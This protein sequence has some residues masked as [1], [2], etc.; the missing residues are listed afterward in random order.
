MNTITNL[1]TFIIRIRSRVFAQLFVF[2]TIGIFSVFE[3]IYAVNSNTRNTEHEQFFIDSHVKDEALIK[4]ALINNGNES[5]FHLFT[6]GKPGEL[7]I[8]NKWLDA[9]GIANFIKNEIHSKPITHINIY[10]CEFAKGQKGKEA[11]SYLETALGVSVSASNNITGKDGDWNL[12]VG[13]V[14]KIRLLED[15]NYNLQSCAGVVGGTN[16]GDDYDG[17]GICNSDDLDDDNDGILDSNEC[18]EALELDFEQIVNTTATPSSPTSSTVTSV[19]TTHTVTSSVE[20]IADAGSISATTTSFDRN[21]TGDLSGILFSGDMNQGDSKKAI[22]TFDRPVYNL[23]FVVTDTDGNDAITFNGSLD[24]VPITLTSDNFSPIAGGPFPSQTGNTFSSDFSAGP[25]NVFQV[26]FNQP[27]DRLEILS[28]NTTSPATQNVQKV[29]DLQFESGCDTDGDNIPDY[30]DLDSDNDGCP[31]A[32]ESASSPYIYADLNADGS[33]NL[34]SFPV[35]TNSSSAT[36]G[37]PNSQAYLAGSSKD[38]NQVSPECDSCNSASSLYADIDGDGVGNDCDLDNDNDGILD[39]SEGCYDTNFAGNDSN[40]VGI[41]NTVYISYPFGTVKDGANK[42][43]SRSNIANIIIPSSIST[44]ESGPGFSTNVMGSYSL[45]V[46][47]IDAVTLNQAIA[48]NEYLEFSFKTVP[49]VFD[50]NIDWFGF[51][52]RVNTNP[53]YTVTYQI[54]NDGFSSNVTTLG[55]V[56]QAD[57]EGGG[58]YPVGRRA[59]DNEN[60]NLY[61]DKDYTVRI[62]IYNVGGPS[63]VLNFDDPILA[64]DYCISDVDGDGILNYLDSDSD[65]DGCP[66]ALEGNGGFTYSDLD[67]DVLTTGTDVDGNGVPIEAS[68][69]QGA[70]TAYNS[71]EQSNVCSP[72][73]PDNPEFIDSDGDGVGDSCDLDDDND[74]ILDEIEYNC[75]TIQLPR[76]YSTNVQLQDGSFDVSSTYGLPDGSIIVNYTNYNET[77]EY[78]YNINNSINT[79]PKGRTEYTITS[80]VPIKLTLNQ[81][82]VITQVGATDYFDIISGATSGSFTQEFTSNTGY[83]DTIVGNRLGVVRTT[84]S[85][86]NI[87]TN[88]G[89]FKWVSKYLITDISFAVGTTD[90]NGGNSAYWIEICVP[91]DSDDDGI[92]DYLDTDSDNDGC[93]DAVEYYGS[94][95]A[96]GTDGNQNYGDGTPPSV[97][98]DGKVDGASYSGDNTNVVVNTNISIDTAPTD[99]IAVEGSD[100]I[101]TATVSSVNTTTFSGGTPDYTTPSPATDSSS[102]LLYQWQISTDNGSTWTDLSNGGNYSGV[103]TNELTVS[104]VLQSQNGVL[105]RV[106]ITHTDLVC[107]EESLSAELQV[108]SMVVTKSLTNADDAIVDTEGETIDYTITVNND[109]NTDLT[110]VVVGDELPDGS[111]GVVT[112]PTGDDGDGIL[113][114]GETWTYTASYVVTQTDLNAGADLVNTASVTT[115]EIT[116]P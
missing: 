88:D 22:I 28:F 85:T 11:V 15:Y 76:F 81:G 116:T 93:P 84:S 104:N 48:N 29:Y 53:M 103:N 109:G 61:P 54:S 9:I 101:F 78:I 20:F 62:Y 26:T 67:G 87:G 37:V 83:D 96:I 21:P 92:A 33:I 38:S 63:E 57:S 90:Y 106:V 1:S 112:G 23:S 30:L 47:N 71:A 40:P 13:K 56:S 44:I 58:V 34:T 41:P 70:G 68:G 108:A 86:S 18:Y 51:L 59:F 77:S 94:T 35:D 100:A 52:N 69:G 64:F 10:G 110:N 74:G 82:K 32:L 39:T 95:D 19:G 24:G 8:N 102:G 99:Q 5:V 114:V 42:N 91:Q 14:F 17:D 7:F 98:S 75:G 31:D 80:T 36:Y 111:L 25:E 113:N 66:D 6:H 49:G 2:I 115:N 107:L 27:V 4:K 46:T 89:S 55:T 45:D 73:H 3:N 60:Y 65:A 72:C 50:A 12:E 97:D 43:S 79:D 105:F 16:P